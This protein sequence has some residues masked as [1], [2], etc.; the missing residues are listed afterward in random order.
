MCVALILIF[1]GMYIVENVAVEWVMISAS[2]LLSV[3][4]ENTIMTWSHRLRP[5]LSVL[6]QFQVWLALANELG[7]HV[8]SHAEDRIALD[9]PC[10]LVVQDFLDCPDARAGGLSTLP[11]DSRTRDR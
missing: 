6:P 3:P 10:S 2:E 7:I 11:G 4:T 5:L 8:E 9:Y 1:E